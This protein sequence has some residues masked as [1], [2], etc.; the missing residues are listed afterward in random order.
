MLA[1][2]AGQGSLPTLIC[3]RLEEQGESFLLAEME[4]HP[5]DCSA[6][7]EVLRF[8]VEKLG[9]LFKDLKKRGVTQVCLAGRV[10]RP[11][12]DPKALDMAT[13]PLVPRMMRAINSGDDG[14]LRETLA[15]FQEKGFAVRAAHELLPDLL[16]NAG[17]AT[18]A[19][20]P[21]AARRDAARGEAIVAALGAADVGQACVVAR[22][23]ALAVE[24]L[25]GT[26]WMLRSL[27][28]RGRSP[29]AQDRVA[30]IAT[31]AGDLAAPHP[32]GDGPEAPL[33]L[34]SGGMLF[35]A[36]KPGQD[37][38]VDL[39]TIGPLT[40]LLAARAGLDG[41][42]IEAGGVMVLDLPL[43]LRMLDAGGMYLWV[44][45]AGVTE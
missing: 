42:V 28:A 18:H 38:R 5:P 36:P 12:I 15:L 4:G 23:Q 20:P 31:L 43:V 16:P 11:V 32:A 39:P 19:Q 27:A 10:A 22:G 45:P 2:I 9:S 26:D 21:E 29:E 25:L 7:R 3:Q 24:A 34:P 6:G 30:Q 35:K 17:V 41:V 1:L 37:R 44:R 8:R 33:D 13:L 14:V 40:V